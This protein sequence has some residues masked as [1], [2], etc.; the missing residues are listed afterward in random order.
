MRSRHEQADGYKSLGSYYRLV[1][2]DVP[3][4]QQE[5]ERALK[6]A[7]GRPDIIRAISFVEASL[8][9][10]DEALEHAKQAV[11]LDPPSPDRGARGRFSPASPAADEARTESERV[12]GLAPSNPNLRN[13]LAMTY[14]SQGDLEGARAALRAAAADVDPATVVAYAAT[15]FDLVWALDPAQLQLLRGLKPEDFNDPGTWAI[16]QPGKLSGRRRRCSS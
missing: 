10:W 7:P 6:I 9:R 16:V 3:R 5:L 2:G 13:L 15:Y 12:V 4:A 14:L 8:G 11:R 1:R